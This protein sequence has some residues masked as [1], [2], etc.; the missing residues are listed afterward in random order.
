VNWISNYKPA[1]DLTV[2]K[3]AESP[4]VKGFLAFLEV[5]RRGLDGRHE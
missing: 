3:Y 2:T 1:P 5:F 4:V